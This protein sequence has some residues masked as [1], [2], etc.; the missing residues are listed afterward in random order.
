MKKII[1]ILITIFLGLSVFA[2]DGVIRP[3]GVFYEGDI[4]IKQDSILFKSLVDSFHIPVNKLNMVSFRT[5]IKMGII[6]NQQY[7]LYSIDI[8]KNTETIKFSKNEKIC[9]KKHEIKYFQVDVCKSN[10]GNYLLTILT[11]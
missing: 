3:N 9:D 11:F 1:L 10:N 2:Q 7:N 4:V 8:R 6:D 5:T